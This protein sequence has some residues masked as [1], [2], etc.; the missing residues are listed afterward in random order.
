ME[1]HQTRTSR[2]QWIYCFMKFQV[3]CFVD[4]VSFYWQCIASCKA[5]PFALMVLCHLFHLFQLHL[6]E[7]CRCRSRQWSS[8]V[9]NGEPI[10]FVFTW[11]DVVVVG[12]CCCRCCC[13][14]WELLFKRHKVLGDGFKYFWCSLLSWAADLYNLTNTPTRVENRTNLM[15]LIW[16]RYSVETTSRHRSVWKRFF[17]WNIIWIL[18]IWG[19]S[20]IAAWFQME[21]LSLDKPVLAIIR[22]ASL[23]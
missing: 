14:G 12:S 16:K 4:V 7:V 18:L 11:L 17:T 5:G 23:G 2:N 13:C 3:S 8:A 9:T 20:K 21:K 6:F 19:L 15:F 22:N 1:I 10:S